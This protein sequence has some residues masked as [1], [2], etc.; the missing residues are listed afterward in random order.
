VVD[1]EVFLGAG[2]AYLIDV[3]IGGSQSHFDTPDDEKWRL[4]ILE[5]A[6]ELVSVD[7]R[8]RAGQALSRLLNV[9]DGLV[10]QG[11]KILVLI[12]TN[13][14]LEKLHPA[15]ARPGRCAAQIHFTPLTSV[16]AARWRQDHL[17]EAPEASGARTLAELYAEVENYQKAKPLRSQVGFLAVR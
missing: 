15:V 13:E 10:G 8:E 4:I 17:V 11:L 5:D 16:E 2:A 1:P 3:L 9:V 14:E 6:G 7:A 12:T